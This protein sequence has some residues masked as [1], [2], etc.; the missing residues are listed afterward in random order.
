M[1]ACE[2]REGREGIER[3]SLSFFFFFFFFLSFPSSFFFVLP[4][5]GLNITGDLFP[6][7]FLRAHDLPSIVAVVG[8]GWSLGGVVGSSATSD[9]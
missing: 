3:I 1:E 7:G 9:R 6:I 8:G 5:L 2:E 4:S